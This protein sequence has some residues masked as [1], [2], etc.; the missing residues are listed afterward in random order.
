MKV[1]CPICGHEF[2]VEPKPTTPTVSDMSATSV[3]I[4]VKS[5]LYCGPYKEIHLSCGHSFR[6]EFS[7]YYKGQKV[8]CQECGKHSKVVKLIDT[9]T[10]KEHD[11]L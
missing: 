3:P 9:V 4:D 7:Q 5:L 2:E 1:K 8:W 6:C 11:R 10:G